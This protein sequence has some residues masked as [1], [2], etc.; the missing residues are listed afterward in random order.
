M[1]ILSVNLETSI[2]LLAVGAILYIIGKYVPIE[3][4]INKVLWVLGLIILIIGAV[5]L[6]VWVVMFAV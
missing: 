2:I 3:P 1:G 5:L 6:I 4:V